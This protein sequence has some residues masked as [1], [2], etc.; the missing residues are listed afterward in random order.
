MDFQNATLWPA[1]GPVATQAAPLAHRAELQSWS[2]GFAAPRWG[3]VPGF[4][5]RTQWC[6]WALGRA[7]QPRARGEARALPPTARRTPRAK[8]STRKAP[9]TPLRAHPSALG[10]GPRVAVPDASAAHPPRPRRPPTAR[11]RVSARHPVARASRPSPSPGRAC[12][13][14]PSW[15]AAGAHGAHAPARGW[16]GGS[17]R[18]GWEST[19]Q[20][21][22]TEGSVWEGP[23][24]SRALTSATAERARGRRRPSGSPDAVQRAYWRRR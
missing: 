14:W 6:R 2:G 23:L 7:P 16:K 3:P 21:R 17:G 10:C 24:P 20:T 4:S 11:P 15:G 9:R 12:A 19:S 5:G 8:L 13:P 18:S 22:E 1:R